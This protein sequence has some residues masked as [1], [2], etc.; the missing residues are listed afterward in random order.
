MPITSHAEDLLGLA[1]ASKGTAAEIATAINNVGASIKLDDLAAP[2]D[3][4]DLNASTLAH[5]L[6]RKLDGVSTNFLD[7]AGNWSVVSSAPFADTQTIVKGSVDATKLLRIEVDGFTAGTTR[8]LTPPNADVTI[9]GLEIAQTFT[10]QQDVTETVTTIADNRGIYVTHTWNPSSAAAAFGYAIQSAMSSSVTNANNMAH[11]YGVYG[12]ATHNGSGAITDTVHGVAGTA[13]NAGVGSV[14]DLIG[15]DFAAHPLGGTTTNAYG[16]K[17]QAS[18]F[19]TATNQYGVYASAATFGSSTTH[20]GVY[21]TSTGAST[22]YCFYAAAGV[23]Q[24]V[25]GAA[26]DKIL[27]LRGIASQSGILLQLQGQSSTTAGREQANIDT[28]WVDS[29][30][31]TRKARLIVTVYDTAAREAMRFE[32]SGTAPMIGSYGVAAVARPSAFTQTYSTATKTHSNAT[33]ATLTD[34][35]A[36]AADTTVQALTDAAGG[37]VSALIT[38]LN[39]NLI[40]ELRNNIADMVAQINALRVDLINN[41]GVTNAVIDDLQSEGWLQ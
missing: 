7:G 10:K 41:K 31:A 9:A 37:N 1:L 16:V 6:L 26:A 32:G 23:N 28:A 33:S 25:A 4:T 14:V 17:A 22:N 40:P 19:G 20:Y 15:G 39:T 35:S 24:F 18:S 29:T 12:T 30:D 27:I 34:N 8:V 2:D 11:L 3:N 36:G 38:N 5:G 13:D 21:G